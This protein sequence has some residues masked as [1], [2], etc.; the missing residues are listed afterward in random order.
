MSLVA[1]TVLAEIPEN[2]VV[3]GVPTVPEDLKRQVRPYLEF[4]LAGFQSWHPQ[5]REILITTR[6]ADTP[7]L[8]LVKQ[9]GGARRQLTFFSE[10][11]AGG[12]FRPKT[13]EY[14]VFSQD[15]GGSEFFQLYRFDLTNAQVTLLTDG[16]SRNTGGAWAESGNQLAYT[17]T[18]RN[19]KDN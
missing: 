17:S 15:T 14:I 3:E 2:L 8:H 7:Q 18:R 16:K 13:G 9:P 19:G 11:V 5:R 4:R 1:V 6:F 12:S 10:P